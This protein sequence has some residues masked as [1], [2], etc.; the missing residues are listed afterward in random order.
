MVMASPGNADIPTFAE[1]EHFP[2]DNPGIHVMR[3]KNLGESHRMHRHTFFELVLVCS[4]Y[5]SHV[6]ED[7]E[8]S[9]RQGNVFLVKPGCAHGYRNRKGV[10]I[11]NILY[12]PT[13]LL[14]DLGHLAECAGYQAFFQTSPNLSD[15]FRFRNNLTLDN[16]RMAEAGKLVREIELE[17]Q[18]AR[19]GWQVA[20]TASF[21]RLVL[22]ISRTVADAEYGEYD[23]MIRINRILQYISRHYQDPLRVTEIAR[24]SGVSIRTLE[25]LFRSSLNTTPGAY[26]NDIRLDKAREL[27]L[28]SSQ[29][30]SEI[31]F[32]TGF[33][34]SNYFTNL[35]SRR[36]QMSPRAYRKHA[37]HTSESKYPAT[38]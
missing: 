35:F 31:S 26:L 33:R 15:E 34:D 36:F 3:R 5:G 11:V 23:E 8:Y 2:P 6:T 16:E 4:G 32:A 14:I 25:R 30:I 12:A 18:Q 22:L 10:E 28:E 1:G 24:Q 13:R 9:L 21:A 38:L 37:S 20:V 27:L 7:G 29:S 17:Q 19:P